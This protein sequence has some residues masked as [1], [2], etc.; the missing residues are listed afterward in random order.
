M[1]VM[2]VVAVCWMVELDDVANGAG[3]TLYINRGSFERSFLF[4]N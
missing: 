1:L 3:V 2:V 4:L